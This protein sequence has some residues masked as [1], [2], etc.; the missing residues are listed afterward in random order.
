VHELLLEHAR[1]TAVLPTTLPLEAACTAAAKAAEALITGT[2]A[3]PGT[4]TMV[5]PSAYEVAYALRIRGKQY[6]RA[7]GCQFELAVRLEAE[8]R[9]RIGVYAVSI[10]QYCLD[11]ILSICRMLQR[12]ARTCTVGVVGAGGI[13]TEVARLSKAFGMRVLGWRRQAAPALNYDEVLSGDDGLAA[14]LST[15]DFVVVAVPKTAAMTGLLNAERL[16]MM[17]RVDQPSAWLINVARGAVVDETALISALDSGV[18]AGA[19]L[20]VFATGCH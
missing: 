16:R 10:A 15:S 2:P 17:K 1:G 20:D 11:H 5:P 14:V 18:V 8:W 19:V 6:Q 3:A 7:A 12:D 13:G 4:T 9:E